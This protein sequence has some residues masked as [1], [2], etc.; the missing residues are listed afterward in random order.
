MAMNDQHKLEDLPHWDLSNVYEGLETADFRRAVEEL[1]AGLD[2]MDEFL[3][4]QRIAKGGAVPATAGDLAAILSEYLEGM[5]D[6]LRLYGTLRSYVYSFVSTDSFNT[7]AKR[8]DSEL[9]LLGVR[10]R[11]QEVY[12]RGWIGTVDEDPA[13]LAAAEAH[14]TTVKEHAFYLGETAE[15][16][17]YLMSAE[18]EI[19]AA[20]LATSGASAWSRLHGVVTSQVQAPFKRNGKVEELPVTVIQNYYHD[21][22]ESLRRQ[23]YETEL[24]AWEGVREPLAACLNGVKGAVNTLDRRRGRRDALHRALDQA[25]IDRETLEAMLGAMRDSFPAFRRY[26]Q[27]KARRLGKEKLPWWDIVAPVGRLEQRFAYTEARDFI[28]QHFATFSGRLVK[29]SER[30][31]EE[32]WID[33]EP[34]RGKVGGGFCMRIPAVDESRI[35]CNFDGSLDQLATIA[36]ELG[37]AYHNECLA[38]RSELGRRTPMTLAETASIFNQTII[39]DATLAQAQD[40]QEELAILESFLS[41][42]AQVIVDIYCRYLFESEVFRRRTEAELSADDLCEIMTRCQRETYGD[43]LDGDYLHPYM[44]AWKPHYYSPELSFYNFPYAFGLLFGLGL[45]GIYQEAGPEGQQEFL[46]Q[47]DELLAGTG[48]AMAADLAT[49]FGIDLRQ[50][51]FWQAGLKVIEGRIERYIAL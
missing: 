22:D 50:P 39:T 44:W 28:L 30:A 12:F 41:D 24:A 49:R 5:N 15:Q 33:A 20:E 40:S 1:R 51:A 35:L 36:H 23:A 14:S 6:L 43:G 37:H 13:A 29:L 32:S 48:G 38:G 46:T 42:A 4:E 34:R 7:T 31:F 45:Y 21:P 18:E 25:R 10:L 26:W 2:R 16:S 47:Y 9:E 19:L 27:N 17:R 3:E 11:R 8:I